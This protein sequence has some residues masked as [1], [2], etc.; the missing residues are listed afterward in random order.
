MEAAEG[1]GRCFTEDV[2]LYFAVPCFLGL[3][4]D[5]LMPGYGAPLIGLVLSAV[6]AEGAHLWAR[7]RP[8]KLASGKGIGAGTAKDPRIARDDAWA[9]TL[10]GAWK[11]T[12]KT[13]PTVE[14]IVYAADE[15][16]E[17]LYGDALRPAFHKEALPIV[18][19]YHTAAGPRDLFVY[20]RAEILC[21]LGYAVFVADLFGDEKGDGWDGAWAAKPR[22]ALKD[23]EVLQQRAAAA[24]KVAK[25]LGKGPQGGE[26]DAERCAALGWCL[27]GRAAVALASLRPEGLKVA[28][29]FHGVFEPSTLAESFDDAPAPRV[30]LC[31][32]ADDP[33]VPEFGATVDALGAAGVPCETHVF[34]GARHGF[35]NPAQ[36]LN[37]ADAF[38]YDAPAAGAAWAIAVH[39]LADA[40]RPEDAGQ[41]S[42]NRNNKTTS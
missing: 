42:P 12:V 29:S 10:R 9:A 28:V 8:S 23:P 34:P 6:V 14:R 37:E 25:Q 5:L 2:D 30:V 41:A 15:N 18:V 39:H 16:G 7:K 20:W 17:A 1:A 19:L 13:S 38:A 21:D 33:F 35:T 32:G 4:V 3:G 27:G 36:A 26:V 40:L 31:H 24:L 22:A 11:G